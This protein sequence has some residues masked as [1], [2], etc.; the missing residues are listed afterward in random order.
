MLNLKL[1][2]KVQIKH[3]FVKTFLSL[4]LV[5]TYKKRKKEEEEGRLCILVNK[6]TLNI[7][8]NKPQISVKVDTNHIPLFQIVQYSHNLPLKE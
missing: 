5:P 6:L 4:L 2:N 8:D 7:K 1:H 3:S